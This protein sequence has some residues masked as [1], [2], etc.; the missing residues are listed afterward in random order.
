[1]AIGASPFVLVDLQNMNAITVDVTR[2]QATVGGGITLE[3]IYAAIAIA[4]QP[5]PT[6]KYAFPGGSCPTVGF[7]TCRFIS[8]WLRAGRRNRYVN[9][10]IRSC[11]R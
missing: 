10:E 9:A 6:L 5:S 2:N 7:G 4:P 1:M 8:R 3:K 11:I